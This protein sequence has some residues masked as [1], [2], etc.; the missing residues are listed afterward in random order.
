[1]RNVLRIAPG[2]RVIAL[3][4]DGWECEVAIT[5]VGKGEAAGQIVERRMNMREPRAKVTLYQCLLKKDHFEWV[6]QKCTEVGVSRFVPVI[7]ARTVARES[8]SSKNKQARW[9]HILR[10]AAE[11]SG[12]G[13]IP[14]IEPPM[15]FAEA[16]ADSAGFDARLIAWEEEQAARLSA[17]MT[18][19]E[20]AK[21]GLYV[22]PE[23][24]FGVDEIEMARSQGVQ[25]VTLGRRILRAET[26]AVVF[27][28]LALDRAGDS[29]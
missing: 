1:M 11:Q 23:G 25:A 24:G 29:G 26:A 8:A 6:L 7:S 9:E 4:N 5:A 2:E 12:R 13:R 18:G 17:T 19:S 14:V 15:A 20:R 21:I 28:A 3:G 22:G 16:L 27:A 10:E